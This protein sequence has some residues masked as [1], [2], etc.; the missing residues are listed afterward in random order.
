MFTLTETSQ[1]I[2]LHNG[3][4]FYPVDDGVQVWRSRYFLESFFYKVFH[5]VEL[6]HREQIGFISWRVIESGA[7]DWNGILEVVTQEG[8]K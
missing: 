4:Y 7:A 3:V 1:R 8:V 5:P 6:R 2:A